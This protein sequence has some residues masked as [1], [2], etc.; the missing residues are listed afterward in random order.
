MGCGQMPQQHHDDQ[1]DSQV[2]D[3]E[4][5]GLSSFLTPSFFSTSFDQYRVDHA[6]PVEVPAALRLVRFGASL[7]V[8]CSANAI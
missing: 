6:Q 2:V 4:Q 3:K 8:H 1:H 7:S 5:A